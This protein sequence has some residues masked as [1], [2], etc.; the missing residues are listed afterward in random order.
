MKAPTPSCPWTALPAE[1]CPE[2]ARPSLVAGRGREACRGR[3]T[4]IAGCARPGCPLPLT[5]SRPA[6]RR[7]TS[8]RAFPWTFSV[9]KT[10]RGANRAPLCLTP[11][12][13]RADPSPN[14]REWRVFSPVRNRALSRGSSPPPDVFPAPCSACIPARKAAL[15]APRASPRPPAW[16]ARVCSL[17]ELTQAHLPPDPPPR[18]YPCHALLRAYACRT[19]LAP[20]EQPGNSRRRGRASRPR[21]VT[22]HTAPPAANAEWNPPLHPLHR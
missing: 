17:D 10:C 1:N 15:A 16:S 14:R 20:T 18:P 8:P 21:P 6:P 13:G 11:F 5:K 9:P 12:A 19:A 7:S 4:I 22:L 2:S 3:R